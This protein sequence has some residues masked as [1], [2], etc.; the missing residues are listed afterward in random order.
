MTSADMGETRAGT[1]FYCLMRGKRNRWISQPGVSLGARAWGR[2][3][4]CSSL[5]FSLLR[6][7]HHGDIRKASIEYLRRVK[8]GGER[9]IMRREDLPPTTAVREEWG[10]G[11]AG[12][13]KL[14]RATLDINS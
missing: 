12:S 11:G 3:A 7:V 1:R 4:C 6:A 10:W 9:E 14:R 8:E 5:S 13:R 2:R